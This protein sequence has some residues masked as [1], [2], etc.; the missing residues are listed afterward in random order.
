MCSSDLLSRNRQVGLK[1]GQGQKLA[2][3]IAG[4]R[5]VAEGVKTTKSVFDLSKKLGVEL[6]ITEQVYRILYEDKDPAQAVKDLMARS[7]KHE[8]EEEA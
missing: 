5:S 1:L 8:H 3:I 7:L 4:T 2:A 6:P